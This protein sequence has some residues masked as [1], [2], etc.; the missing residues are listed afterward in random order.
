MAGSLEPLSI[1]AN[2]V[3]KSHAPDF[4]LKDDQELSEA[5]QNV[6]RIMLAWSSFPGIYAGLIR[7]DIPWLQG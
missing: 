7:L 3:Q 1:K 2:S 6:M 5:A 4:L